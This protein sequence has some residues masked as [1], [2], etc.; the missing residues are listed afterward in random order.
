MRPPYGDI[1]YGELVAKCPHLV[2]QR[3]SDRVRAISLAMGFTPIIWTGVG[4]S[5]FDTN[6]WHI[7]SILFEY[8]DGILTATV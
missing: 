1:E 3:H 7:V 8:R 4:S 2:T 5:N 6:D